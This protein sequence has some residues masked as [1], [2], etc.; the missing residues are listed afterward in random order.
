MLHLFI[1]ILLMLGVQ[2]SET[3]SGQVKVSGNASAAMD[4]TRASADFERLGG[5]PALNA[6]V[7]VDGTEG[8]E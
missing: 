7:V 6:V 5:E 8:K 4:K 1:S 3:G 2:F